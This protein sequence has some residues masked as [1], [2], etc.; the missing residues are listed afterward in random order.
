MTR[1]TLYIIQSV[2]MLALAAWQGLQAVSASR[3]HMPELPE[4]WITVVVLALVSA[5]IALTKSLQPGSNVPWSYTGDRKPIT[6]KTYRVAAIVCL[7]LVAFSI[8]LAIYARHTYTESQ[9]L[10]CDCAEYTP[11]TF[12]RYLPWGFSALVVLGVL[13]ARKNFLMSRKLRRAELLSG[14]QQA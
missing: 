6:S 2:A 1:R 10:A 9:Q 5:G 14:A 13:G 4:L 12:F 11:P 8:L 7:Y 3:R